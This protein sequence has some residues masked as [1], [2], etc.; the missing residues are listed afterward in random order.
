MIRSELIHIV[1][2]RNPHLY[3]ADVDRIVDTILDEIAATLAQGGRVEL[4]GFG[5]FSVRHRPSRAGRNPKNGKSAFVEEKWVPFFK[6][7]K[8]I[9]DRLNSE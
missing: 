5:S 1:A 8:E 9:Q 7:G 2:A 3:H 4:R 6:A